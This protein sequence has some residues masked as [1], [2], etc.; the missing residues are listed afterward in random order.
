MEWTV[1]MEYEGEP[2]GEAVLRREGLYMSVACDCR[3]VTDQVVRAYLT[4][5]GEPYC[6]GVLA[7]EGGRLRL[8]RR[9]PVS[10]FPQPPY[11]TAAVSRTGE[12]WSPWTG[13]VEG[14]SVSDALSRR[15]GGKTVVALP[16][17]P[18]A[19]FPLLPLAPRCTPR[20]IGNGQYLTFALE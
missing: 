2:C 5:A 3:I 1:Q 7:P 16:F 12:L 13:E 9:V 20:R 4:G 6:L 8:R 10:R 11:E 18:D 19:P 14:M 17:A 15:E